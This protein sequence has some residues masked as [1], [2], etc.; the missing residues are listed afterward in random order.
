MSKKGK[1][2]IAVTILSPEA[3]VWKGEVFSIS[4]ANIEGTFDIIPDHARFMTFIEKT[5]IS[6]CE[7]DD[8]ERVFTFDTAVLFFQ[9]NVAKIYI[10]KVV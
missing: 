4:S 9:D 5:P 10:H 3:I 1:P 2:T 7:L 8:S 6:L